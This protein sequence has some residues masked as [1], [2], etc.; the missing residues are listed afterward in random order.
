MKMHEILRPKVSVTNSE[1]IND[2][3]LD[4]TPVNIFDPHLP[5]VDFV[6]CGERVELW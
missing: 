4:T 1:V 3:G 5:E 6:L 2:F